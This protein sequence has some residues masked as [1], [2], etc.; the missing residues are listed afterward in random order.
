MPFLKYI[1]SL[2]SIFLANQKIQKKKHQTRERTSR[3]KMTSCD[4]TPKNTTSSCVPVLFEAPLPLSHPPWPWR[5]HSGHWA[6][7]SLAPLPAASCTKH[8][9]AMEDLKTMVILVCY[10]SGNFA[11]SGSYLGHGYPLSRWAQTLKQIETQS[12]MLPHW[13]VAVA[14]LWTQ[15]SYITNLAKCLINGHISGV[16]LEEIARLHSSIT[17]FGKV[18]VCKEG[19]YLQRYGSIEDICHT[20][21]IFQN[22]L[23]NI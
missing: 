19:A 7:R 17:R 16:P 5:W 12:V 22:H 8:T 9:T 10:E 6:N 1:F 14:P 2:C 11:S 13:A 23:I 18:I 20:S 3:N 21:K 4:Q 15:K